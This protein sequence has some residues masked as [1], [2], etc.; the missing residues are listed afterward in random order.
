MWYRGSIWLN[1]GENSLVQ[2][3]FGSGY[4]VSFTS[5]KKMK[6]KKDTICCRFLPF[7]LPVW[8]F[9][10]LRLITILSFSFGPNHSRVGSKMGD[11]WRE[12]FAPIAHL[13]PLL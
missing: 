5:K 11:R 2:T 13:F 7:S 4:F 1:S 12:M 10:I 9:Y 3:V 8:R 6:K